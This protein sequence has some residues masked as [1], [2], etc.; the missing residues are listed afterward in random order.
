MKRNTP[1][2]ILFALLLASSAYAAGAQPVTVYT[3][4]CRGSAFW[5][6]GPCPEGAIPYSL[7]QGSDG[8]FY[9]NAQMSSEG[10]SDTGGTV[11]SLTP[12]GKLTVLHTFTGG[13]NNTFANGSNPGLLVEGSDGKL[14]GSTIYGGINGGEGF[15]GDGVLFRL[16]KD[17]SGFRVIHRFCSEA[18]C[19]DGVTTTALLA[20]AD[21]K[22]YGTTFAG[23]TGSCSGSGCGTIFKITPSSGAY[24]VV[25]NFPDETTD[26]YEPTN[27]IVGPNRSL[28]GNSGRLFEYTPSTGVLQIIPVDFPLINGQQSAGAVQVVGANGNFYG[29]YGVLGLE[30]TGLFEV[31]TDGSHLQLFP[32]YTTR[33][34]AGSP[35]GLIL[36]SDDNFWMA[37]FNGN[38]GYGDII[39]LSSSNGTVLQ[40]FTPFSTTAAVGA[41]PAGI[42]QA[43]NGTFWGTTTEFGK[44]SN[45][46]FAAGVAFS[47]NA[48]LPPR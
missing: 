41:Y 43:K 3:F 4:A 32:F 19:T 40:T 15:I 11:F 31:E 22:L 20:G 1:V 10:K 25:F 8:N 7:L 34:G 21:G 29:L 24:E 13:A 45:G 35:D 17:G 44:V 48:G 6:I 5:R 28:Y 47:L 38:S 12:A 37:D 16:N 39:S 36:A 18:N 30:G 2:A 46:H 33:D 14:Y 26:G 23:G 42:V 27:L 9:G